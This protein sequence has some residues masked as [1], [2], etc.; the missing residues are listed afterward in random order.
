[1]EFIV[2]S[3]YAICVATLIGILFMAVMVIVGLYYDWRKS[4]K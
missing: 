3:A 1:M 2:Y 4:R